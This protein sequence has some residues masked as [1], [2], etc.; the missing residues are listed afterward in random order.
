MSMSKGAEEQ[1]KRVLM[2][3]GFFLSL[4]LSDSTLMVYYTVCIYIYIYKRPWNWS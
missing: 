4:S 2:K 3:G 1:E